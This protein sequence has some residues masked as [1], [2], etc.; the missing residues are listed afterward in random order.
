MVRERYTREIGTDTG[1]VT[2]IAQEIET[3]IAASTVTESTSK[4]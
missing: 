2:Q 1:I 3:W 4:R